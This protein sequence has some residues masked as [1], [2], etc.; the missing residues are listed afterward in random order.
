M[1]QKVIVTTRIY[2]FIPGLLSI[3]RMYWSNIIN[4]H[5]VVKS[6]KV[7]FWGEGKK[8]KN[9]W[10]KTSNR[11]PS[12][13]HRIKHKHRLGDLLLNRGLTS[14]EH[15][16]QALQE[17]TKTH[18]PLGKILLQHQWV[19]EDPLLHILA[20]QHSVETVNISKNVVL[21]KTKLPFFSTQEYTRLIKIGILPISLTQ[22]S[23]LMVSSEVVDKQRQ[24]EL[25]KKTHPLKV[26]FLTITPHQKEELLQNSQLKNKGE[27][28]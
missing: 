16:K 20:E 15:L 13:E 14:T 22:H 23:L 5:A 6:L 21:S 11:F 24:F 25:K 12:Q 17:Q 18:Q 10:L 27:K 1:V 8:G 9:K 19:E 28:K 26:H 4:C 7:F 3:P 2:G